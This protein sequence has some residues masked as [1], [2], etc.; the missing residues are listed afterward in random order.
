LN[1]GTWS[2]GANLPIAMENM[3]AAVYNGKIY[4]FG[5]YDG[6]EPDYLNADTYIYDPVANSFTKST[7]IPTQ[8]YGGK[9]FVYGDK[10]IVDSGYNLWYNDTLGGLSGA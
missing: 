7:A 9:A 6:V 2:S 5:G 10:I 4:L 3:A 1:S 8:V